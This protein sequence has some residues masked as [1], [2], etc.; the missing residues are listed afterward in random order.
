[1]CCVSGTVTSLA[2][3]LAEE[4][5]NS[6]NVSCIAKISRFRQTAEDKIW[7]VKIVDMQLDEKLQ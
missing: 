6:Q 4:A 5:E 3:E 2:D 7:K 1:M